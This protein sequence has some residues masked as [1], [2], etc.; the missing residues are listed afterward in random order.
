VATRRTDVY[1]AS[2]LY[3][4]PVLFSSLSFLSRAMPAP[5]IWI[6]GAKRVTSTVYKFW[7]NSLT[8]RRA[9][10]RWDQNR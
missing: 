7:L 1:C 3:E 8:L 2:V 4:L 9:D 10:V 5:I 6:E